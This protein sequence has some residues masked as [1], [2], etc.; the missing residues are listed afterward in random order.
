MCFDYH[1]YAILG[2]TGV[3]ANLFRLLKLERDLKRLIDQADLFVAVD[4]PGLNL[5]LAA[6]AKQRGVPVLYYISPQVWAWGEKRVEKMKRN[7]DR[8]AVILPF[9]QEW[10]PAAGYGGGV[11]GA[12][13][14]CGSSA[15]RAP[16]GAGP[17]RPGP[18][19]GEPAP[20]GGAHSPVDARGRRAP[21]RR[22]PADCAQRHRPRGCV[23]AAPR[24][25]RYRRRTGRRSRR[26]DGWGD[27][28]A[29]RVGNRHVADGADGH[30]AGGGVPCPT[31][32]T[33]SWPGV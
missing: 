24:R 4:Y 5:R 11:R 3:V 9:E 26:G 21:R 28:R 25:R 2:F 31:C 18:A 19:P 23:P 10:F 12:S 30:A 7:I 1:D 16:S 33:T 32:S 20:G 6:Y 8:L 15:A 14:R 22:T 13:L 17:P 29:G 27:R